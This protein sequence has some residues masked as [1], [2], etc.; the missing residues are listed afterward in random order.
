[1]GEP[2][3][4][5]A[6]PAPAPELSIT[7]EGPTRVEPGEEFVYTIVVENEG[8]AEATT[9][10]VRD[11]LPEG[12]EFVR[13]EPGEPTCSSTEDLQNRHRVTCTFDTLAPGASQEIQLVVMAPNEAGV[14]ENVA[15]VDSD[16]TESETSN[17]ER[18]TVD[19]YLSII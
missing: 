16:Q 9:V 3:L 7:K 14:I 6:E 11:R 5:S 19:T 12:V 8:E 18:T 13:S 15:T 10:V 17:T 4:G 1:M 2:G